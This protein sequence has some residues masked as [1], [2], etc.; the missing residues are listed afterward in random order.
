MDG[1]T[2]EA[3]MILIE[4]IQNNRHKSLHLLVIIII[5]NYWLIWNTSWNRNTGG[6]NNIWHLLWPQGVNSLGDFDENSC[7]VLRDLLQI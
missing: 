5:T 1:Q 7:T 3:D 2:R 6:G 4:L